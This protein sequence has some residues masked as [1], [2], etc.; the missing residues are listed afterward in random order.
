MPLLEDKMT[1]DSLPISEVGAI[2]DNAIK[3]LE[4]IG[5]LNS[6]PGC[7]VHRVDS[8]RWDSVV[9]DITLDSRRDTL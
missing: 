3:T 9:I 6:I 8:L 1:L 4:I 2:R 7:K 5:H